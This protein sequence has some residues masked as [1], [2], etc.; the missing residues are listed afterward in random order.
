ME[1]EMMPEYIG[2]DCMLILVFEVK[3]RGNLC[4]YYSK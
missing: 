4:F 2:K 3:G 1:M